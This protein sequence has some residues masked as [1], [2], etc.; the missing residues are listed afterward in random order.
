MKEYVLMILS[1][2]FVYFTPVLPLLILVSVFIFSDT[3]LGLYTAKKLKKEI[4]SRKLARI[5]TKLIIYTSAMLLI[6]LLDKL[7]FGM[8]IDTP[9][10]ITKLGSGVL[11]FIEVFSMDENIKKI[12]KDRGLIH[13][14]TKS[15]DFIK[16]IKDKFNTSVNG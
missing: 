8:F 6:F 1:V 14:I 7:V 13:Y 4:T 3:L 16:N 2:L 10:I 9:F 12:N 15:F 11:C 5:I